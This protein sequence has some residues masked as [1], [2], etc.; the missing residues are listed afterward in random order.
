MNQIQYKNVG[1]SLRAFREAKRMSQ[2]A[3]A[4]AAGIGRSTLVHLENGA[5]VRLAKIAAVASTL[6][7]SLCAMAEPAAPA[8]PAALVARLLARAQMNER[9]LKLQNAH[10]RLALDLILEKPAA[11]AALADARNMVEL[12][13]RARTCSPFYIDA[14]RKILQGPAMDVGKALAQMDSQWESALMQ[15]SPF[16]AVLAGVND[17]A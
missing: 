16:G 11:C 9:N 7:V 8:A 12:W 10:L 14:W 5:D 3:V 4:K 17:Q 13:S 15:N 2:D 1:S 6:G